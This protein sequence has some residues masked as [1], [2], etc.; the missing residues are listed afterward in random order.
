MNAQEHK[1][2]PYTSSSNGLPL[3]AS[4]QA[5]SSVTRGRLSKDVLCRSR[6]PRLKPARETAHSRTVAESD[7]RTGTWQIVHRLRRVVTDVDPTSPRTMYR[8]CSCC[9][10]SEVS[11]S[12]DDDPT[13][14]LWAFPRP[15]PE[16]DVT[17]DIIPVPWTGEVRA[18]LKRALLVYGTATRGHRDGAVGARFDAFRASSR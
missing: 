15:S 12:P 11:E 5:R 1:K 2:H 9:R 3:S 17:F 7:R 8:E 14:V 18:D 4:G 13:I 6:S 10:R 16:R